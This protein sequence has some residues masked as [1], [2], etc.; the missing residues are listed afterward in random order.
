MYLEQETYN[1]I[2]KSFPIN[3][4]ELLVFDQNNRILL[5]KR[6]NEPARGQWW[7]PGGRILFGESRKEAA[8][9][10]LKDE[11]GLS[12]SEMAQIAVLEYSVKNTSEK[13]DQHIISTV[14]RVKSEVSVVEIDSQTSEYKWAD[15]LD[16]AS[17]VEHDFIKHLLTA[18][19]D[20]HPASFIHVEPDSPEQKNF[21]RAELYNV[22]VGSMAVH[23]VDL[24]VRNSKGEIL[25]V[26]R[27][28]HP[29]KGEWWVP[30]GRVHF[31]ELRSTA[32][33]RKL[34]QECGLK[35]KIL[36]QGGSYDLFLKG[37]EGALYHVVSTLFHVEAEDLG[38]V[39]IDEQSSEYTWMHPDDIRKL[40]QQEFMH[41]ILEE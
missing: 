30:G 24:F 26:K 9:R 35:G 1:E 13:Y 41:K 16:W 4:V 18:Q 6:Q 21:I 25:L 12:P 36:R 2:K 15:A 34:S 14:F 20:K 11:C 3:A 5:F 7:V 8:K 19:V 17:E 32:A 39:K 22:I 33:R 37:E 31:M 10:L 29:A 40:S 38:C 27:N 28:N 23:C